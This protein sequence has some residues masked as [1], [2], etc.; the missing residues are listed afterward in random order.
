MGAEREVDP[1]R[2]VSFGRAERA[3]R[4]KKAVDLTLSAPEIIGREVFCRVRVKDGPSLRRDPAT[5][6]TRWNYEDPMAETVVRGVVVGNQQ[7]RLDGG[8]FF[9]VYVGDPDQQSR[10]GD[11]EANVLFLP[12][13]KVEFN[14]LGQRHPRQVLDFIRGPDAVNGT[15]EVVEGRMTVSLGRRSSASR[16]FKSR[17]LRYRGRRG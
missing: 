14:Q 11:G 9:I 7:T 15:Y 10:L 2:N 8:L 5:G 16:P 17:G 1:P 4:L 12:A 13:S 6:A 3:L